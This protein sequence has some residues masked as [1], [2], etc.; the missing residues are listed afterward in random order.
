MP[1][2]LVRKA[3]M[4]ELQWEREAEVWVR[5]VWWLSKLRGNWVKPEGKSAQCWMVKMSLRPC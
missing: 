3:K 1:H 4:G 5:G 2:G